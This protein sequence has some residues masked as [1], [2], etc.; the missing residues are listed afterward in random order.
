M[1]ISCLPSAATAD[2]IRKIKPDG[3]ILKPFEREKIRL[4][5]ELCR[6]NHER[7]VEYKARERVSLEV[8]NQLPVG[9]IVTENKRII[10]CNPAAEKMFGLSQEKIIGKYFS[11]LNISVA[12]DYGSASEYTDIHMHLKKIFNNTQK[13]GSIICRINGGDELAEKYVSVEIRRLI[14]GIEGGPERLMSIIRDV[15]LQKRVIEQFNLSSN[16]PLLDNSCFSFWQMKV[17]NESEIYYNRIFSGLSGL[18]NILSETDANSIL[19]RICKD[20]LPDFKQKFADL[21]AGEFKKINFDIRL[22]KPNGLH[23]HIKIIAASEKDFFNQEDMN[24]FGVSIDFDNYVSD[25]EEIFSGIDNVK[26][27]LNSLPFGI[28]FML[29]RKIIWS[30]STFVS[31][32]DPEN[33]DQLAD[34][35]YEM[36][37]KHFLPGGKFT[38]EIVAHNGWTISVSITRN[39]QFGKAVS[40][41]VASDFIRIKKI[42][43]AIVKHYEREKIRR[44]E[45][46]NNERRLEERLYNTAVA[47]AMNDLAQKIIRELN[48]IRLGIGGIK[49]WNAESE[50]KLPDI[51]YGFVSGIAELTERMNISLD[52]ISEVFRPTLSFEI[53]KLDFNSAIKNILKLKRF[54]LEYL[55]IKLKENYSADSPKVTTNENYLMLIIFIILERSIISLEKSQ[56]ADK[57]LE[58]KTSA[59]GLTARLEI[60]DNVSEV[61]PTESVL[62]SMIENKIKNEETDL[63]IINLKII[64]LLA[65]KMHLKVKAE[66]LPV[67]GLKIIVDFGNIKLS[68]FI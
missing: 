8:Q 2:L 32:F 40:T 57:Y 51:I 22:I 64:S 7:E 14:S 48:A 21:A 37:K 52:N 67:R 28:G 59:N 61:I 58:I 26:N 46:I 66:K 34:S 13:I 12:T 1:L 5:L 45:S 42:R 3:F 23:R 25:N 6:A 19:N 9:I 11:D 24:I 47:L 20:D 17:K 39:E 54:N 36:L 62:N 68:N 33:R 38:G 60:A 65:Q 30:N 50:V 55:K 44:I 41:I 56:I 29:G 53:R 63:N 49:A 27:I 16:T 31:L 4:M 43:E 35:D 18:Y 10:S 15:S